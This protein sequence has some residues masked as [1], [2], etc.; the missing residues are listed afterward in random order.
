MYGAIPPP[1][2]RLHGIETTS[3]FTLLRDYP[4]LGFLW[5]LFAKQGCGETVVS[6]I[7]V[8]QTEVSG[9]TFIGP[10]ILVAITLHFTTVGR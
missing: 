6:K 8:S 10:Q 5:R 7:S 3:P 4:N 2:L 1:P 9:L